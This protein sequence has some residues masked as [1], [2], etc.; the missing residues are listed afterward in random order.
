MPEG[1]P[2]AGENTRRRATRRTTTPPPAVQE[3]QNGEQK[4]GEQAARDPLPGE[5]ALPED[6][7]AI[8]VE[9]EPGPT[10]EDRDVARVEPKPT[11]EALERL[12]RE[13]NAKTVDAKTLTVSTR[14]AVVAFL[15]EGKT[16]ETVDKTTGKKSPPKLVTKEMLAR[17]LKVSPHTITA[18]LTV[19]RRTAGARI[20]KRWGIETAIGFLERTADDCYR[21]ARELGDPALAW[22]IRSN[23]VKQLKELGAFGGGKEQDGFRVTFETVGPQL[24]GLTRKLEDAFRPELTGERVVEGRL[25]LPTKLEGEEPAPEA[26]DN[27]RRETEGVSLPDGGDT[28]PNSGLVRETIEASGEPPEDETNEG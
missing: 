7:D 6:L 18:D 4:G 8:A 14:R 24:A 21:E 12:I 9:P 17:L 22:M 15:A 13:L 10:R 16:P 1:D 23:F 25:A 20:V 2:A 19:I 26:G 11:L 5:L 3:V 27:A 28:D